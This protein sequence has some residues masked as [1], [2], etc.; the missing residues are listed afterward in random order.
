MDAIG[1]SRFSGWTEDEPEVVTEHHSR[2]Q[3][4]DGL[5]NTA[6]PPGTPD[7][8]SSSLDQ[9]TLN[10]ITSAVSIGIKAAFNDYDFR[11]YAS[12]SAVQMR[13]PG[14]W[15]SL[16]R[17]GIVADVTANL[18]RAL[19]NING[20]LA[21]DTHGLL[22]E[23]LH[24]WPQD[25]TLDQR[26]GT[27]KHGYSRK[28]AH[29]ICNLIV[30]DVFSAF[31]PYL[32][33]DPAIKRW[34]SSFLH[35]E[36][37]V[38]FRKA[39]STVAKRLPSDVTS[40][41]AHLKVLQQLQTGVIR[42]GPVSKEVQH[43]IQDELPGGHE[44]S[45]DPS[46]EPSLN[47]NF[48]HLM[49]VYDA[50]VA[51]A[52]KLSLGRRKDLD[53]LVGQDGQIARTLRQLESKRV[54]LADAAQTV[55][56]ISVIRNA[57]VQEQMQTILQEAA[58]IQEL[59]HV[60]TD[61]PSLQA[62][63]SLLLRVSRLAVTGPEIDRIIA[64]LTS[65]S[66][67]Y[68]SIIGAQ[69]VVAAL[70]LLRNIPTAIPNPRGLRKLIDSIGHLADSTSH[71]KRTLDM[72]VEGKQK[73]L[74]E[75]LTNLER[76]LKP[77]QSQFAAIRDEIEKKVAESLDK[78]AVAPK[79]TSI[80]HQL[81]EGM[82]LATVANFFS[83]EATTP[84]EVWGPEQSVK[85]FVEILHQGYRRHEPA[86]DFS[87]Y[88][89]SLIALSVALDP[90][91]RYYNAPSLGSWL[92][93]S[94]L[95]NTFQAKYQSAL[96]DCA[97]QY[98]DSE[99][100]S[101]I[102]VAVDDSRLTLQ[103]IR[104]LLVMVRQRVIEDCCKDGRE[105][106]HIQLN[107]VVP[108]S[109]HGGLYPITKPPQA[110]TFDIWLFNDDG[111]QEPTSNSAKFTL[112]SSW[113]AF[114]PANAGRVTLELEAYREK[115]ASRFH[116]GGISKLQNIPAGPERARSKSQP[117]T[118]ASSRPTSRLFDKF[119]SSEKAI[120]AESCEAVGIHLWDPNLGEDLANQG[121]VAAPDSHAGA[122][123]AN[124]DGDKQEP[125]FN[126]D[127]ALP[128][129]KQEF[130]RRPLSQSS[131][132]AAESV[133][134]LLHLGGDGASANFRHKRKSMS[135]SVKRS[136]IGSLQ[137][138]R[139]TLTPSLCRRGS[140]G[141]MSTT[142]SGFRKQAGSQ[143]SREPPMPPAGEIMSP[144][145]AE[146]RE[147][148]GLG[149]YYRAGWL[150][151]PDTTRALNQAGLSGNPEY[152]ATLQHAESRQR[153]IRRNEKGLQYCLSSA[154]EKRIHDQGRQEKTWGDIDGPCNECKRLGR[155]CWVYIP[156]NFIIVKHPTA[157]AANDTSRVRATNGH[158]GPSGSIEKP[159]LVV[160]TPVRSTV[161]AISGSDMKKKNSKGK[162]K[163]T[164]IDDNTLRR[165]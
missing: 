165:F 60:L 136:S 113:S 30:N 109:F 25:T 56:D 142:T 55:Q 45:T 146:L 18:N 73:P 117:P 138:L 79:H 141:S 21:S 126:D 149:T 135:D 148:Y 22:D 147:K 99:R 161:N 106:K 101:F 61:L 5:T 50:L 139:K 32:A 71:V 116:P 43:A 164:G 131:P 12:D 112:H 97:D 34:T 127:A 16:F 26:Q 158:G 35:E 90:F 78:I 163:Q 86:A 75:I 89:R 49:E 93:T 140:H 63:S 82:V 58:A 153:M 105:V 59:S 28:S 92:L 155:D 33:S 85:A 123:Q 119:R 137:S 64:E 91:M 132:T 6:A 151:G 70:E 80:V 17:D 88:K 44:N 143:P 54:V 107:I 102:N 48:V 100:R 120:D 84:I 52:W 74:D 65:D 108:A 122:R 38:D 95:D 42:L 41:L 24:A 14:N 62:V 57:A 3:D 110:S 53:K 145:N 129:A 10:S 154:T 133:L 103:R 47:S 23:S 130:D 81:P 156:S 2:S 37:F 124:N 144:V 72:V 134:Q 11:Q 51:D 67:R 115:T 39:V 27:V 77:R 87:T 29:N 96:Q 20:S 7:R 128:S 31:T 68:S 121:H 98:Q 159:N 94:V 66:E 125:G 150:N 13:S 114:A 160:Q 83:I 46:D 36:S 19:Q 152:L 76:D 157:E 118:R 111:Q 1:I 8:Q 162:E 9:H 4:D 15:D 40:R 104:V 69:N